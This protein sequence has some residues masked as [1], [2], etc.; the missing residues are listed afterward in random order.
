MH[1]FQI[2]DSFGNMIFETDNPFN[3]FWDGYINGKP[4]QQD[5]YVYYFKSNEFE[6]HGTITVFY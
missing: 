5:V 1:S 3:E 2:F 6:K 4:A